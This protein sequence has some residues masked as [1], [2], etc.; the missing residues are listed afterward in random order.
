[1]RNNNRFK[2]TISVK[3]FISEFGENFSSNMKKRLMDL[4]VRCVLK[5]DEVDHILNLKH[6]E[7]IKFDCLNA[8]EKL[9]KKEYAYAQFAVIEGML[10]FCE[11]SIQNNEISPSPIIKSIYDGLNS[12]NII[13]EEGKNFKMVD[14]SNIDYVVDSILSSCPQVSQA[15]KDIVKEMVSRADNK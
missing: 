11:N 4:E 5:R 6:V 13:I 15:Y 9:V 12:A 2:S 7:H 8:S 1:M 10:Y 14:D 3:M